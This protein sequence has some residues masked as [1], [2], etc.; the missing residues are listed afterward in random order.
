M[1]GCTYSYTMVSSTGEWITR[2]DTFFF[3]VFLHL[4]TNQIGIHWFNECKLSQ[5]NRKNGIKKLQLYLRRNIFFVWAFFFK[6]ASCF[7]YTSIRIRLFPSI[8]CDFSTGTSLPRDSFG[9]MSH[10]VYNHQWYLCIIEY[11]LLYFSH[12]S[13]AV[14]KRIRFT[15]L[16]KNRVTRR[17]ILHSVWTMETLEK[18]KKNNFHV[19]E[20][21]TYNVCI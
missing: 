13:K 8:F 1:I 12:Y 18:E 7:L 16:S 3:F 19:L 21:R 6:N 20:K 10:S 15:E 4:V 9:G 14:I 5:V 17:K 2:W 11:H